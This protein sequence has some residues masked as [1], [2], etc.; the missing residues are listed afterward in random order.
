MWRGEL[1]EF[2]GYF[3]EVSDREGR[4]IKEDKQAEICMV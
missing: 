1:E 2:E 3:V 4:E